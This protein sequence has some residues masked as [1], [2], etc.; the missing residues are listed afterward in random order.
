MK[1]IIAV[2]L[3]LGLVLMTIGLVVAKQNMIKDITKTKNFPKQKLCE[4]RGGVWKELPNSC[5]DMCG[6]EDMYCL[7]VFTMG[8]DC[9]ED[10]CWTGHSCVLKLCNK[11]QVCL[12]DNSENVSYI[13]YHGNG[14]Y[15]TTHVVRKNYA[16][17]DKP[18]KPTKTKGPA[19]YKLMGVSWA[20][21][22]NYVAQDK[23][24][25]SI[26]KISI[27]TWDAS[28]GFNLLGGGSVDESAGFE[29]VM[30]GKN[31]YSKGD[32]P[33]TGVIAVCRTWHNIYTNEIVEYDIMFDT[34]F[35]WGDATITP[36]VMD[37]QNI[38]THEIGHVFGL[39]DL[40]KRP[41]A[42]Q[43]MYGYSSYGDISKRD[44]NTG[45]IAGIQTIYGI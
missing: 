28:T 27:G 13:K 5:V 1:K 41:C 36:N 2:S 3:I 20:N 44:L 17:P 37:Y 45:D 38:A 19:C 9:G 22:P 16:K 34:D 26:A 6:K 10:K 39:L 14:I 4:K 32:Y 43:T 15:S 21:T 35:T 24:L 29:A 30:D 7:Q 18:Q 11:K 42:K 8:C 40:Y 23:G 33:S 31:S 12:K 25:L